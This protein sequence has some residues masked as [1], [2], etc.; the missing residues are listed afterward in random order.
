M[1]DSSHNRGQT[2]LL[3]VVA[4]VGVGLGVGMFTF[5]YGKGASYL[6]NDPAACANCHIMEPQYSAWLTG[7]HRKAATCNDCHTPDG[8][9]AKYV[10]KA[11]N[12]FWHST[13]F[14]SGIFHEPIQIKATNR[15]IAEQR[16]RDCHAP[17]V[18][19]ILANN[20]GSVSCLACHPS[21]GHRR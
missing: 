10:T 7:S 18:H 14:T 12:G 8:T 17:M 3:V 13:A 16:C 15:A 2:T 1:R 19:A 6:T 4:L 5:S 20:D 9:I 11:S 21:V